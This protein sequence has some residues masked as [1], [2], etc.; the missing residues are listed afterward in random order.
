MNARHEIL[1]K[2]INKV[3]QHWKKLILMKGGSLTLLSTVAALSIG[4]LM[5]SFFELEGSARFLLM[6]G[7]VTTFVVTLFWTLVRPLLNV[8]TEIQ[9]A[10]YLEEK[11]PQLEDRLVTAVELG[12]SEHPGTSSR[13]LAQLLDD[14][15]IHIQPLNLAKSLH[16]KSAVV[17]SSF[18]MALLLFLGAMIPANLDFFTL[19]TNRIFSPWEFRNPKLF[20]TFEVSPGSKRIPKASAQEIRA[21]ITG[22]EPEE[23]VLYYSDGD[24]SWKKAE[25]DVTGDKGVFVY[26]FFNIQSETQYYVK[27]DEKL[28]DIFTFTVYEAPKINRVDLTYIYP[29]YTG[30]KSKKETDTGDVWAP[31]GT[32]IK[33]AAVADKR[34]YKAE[35]ILGENEEKLEISISADSVVTASFKVTS[36]SF[37]KILITDTDGLTND[38]PP[39]YYIHALP[40]QPPILTIDRPGHDIQA[41]MLEEVPV[42]IEVRDD[43]GLPSVKLLYTVN[44]S[45]SKELTL[46]TRKTSRENS[47]GY[48]EQTQEFTSEYLFYLEDLKVQPGDFLTYH[49]QADDSRDSKNV[50]SV[51]SEIFFIS[52]RSFD[53]EFYRSMSQGGQGGGSGGMGGKLSETQ[54][55]IIVATW[56]LQQKKKKIEAEELANN[57]HIIVESQKNLRDVTQSTL[58]QMQQRAIFSRES[59][60][61]IPK[62]YSAAIEA[63][64]RAIVELDSKQ[65]KDALVPEREA[66]QSL[67][68]AEAQLKQVQMQRAQ[69]QGAGSQATMDELA[70]LFDEEMDKLKNKYETLRQNQQQ[71]KNEQMNDALKKVKDLA[72]RQQQLNRQTRDLARKELPPQEKKRRIEELRRKQEEIRRQT[73]ELTRKMQRSGQSNSNLP[74]DV[75]DDLRRATNEMNNASNNLRQNNMDRA[76]AKGTQALNRLKRLQ[77]KLQQNQ[78]ESLRR[79]IESL[80]QQFERLAEA[81]RDLTKDV[82][83]LK[84]Q[85][86]PNQNQLQEAREKQATLKDNFETSKGQVNSLSRQ[87]R[88]NKKEFSREIN[89]LLQEMKQAGLDKK[90]ESAENL[91]KQNRLNSALQAEKDILNSLEQLREKLTNM[92]GIFAE[93]DEEKLDLALNQTRRLRENLESM[94]RETQGFER[95]KKTQQEGKQNQSGQ[96]SENRQAGPG[97]GQRPEQTV[98][99]Q[100]LDWNKQLAENLR[101]LQH[102]QRAV[103]GDSSLSREFQK[104]SQNMEG[105]IRSFSGGLPERFQLI[106][107]QVLNP[108]KAFE[109]ELAHKLEILKNKEKLFLAREEK[110]PPEYEA[111]VEKYYEVLSKTKK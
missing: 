77:E 54:K 105:M 20:P 80:E 50:E 23:V 107:E 24:S 110:I 43:Y 16:S 75:Q 68:R 7:I 8:P 18:A 90:M 104:L 109:A 70:Q 36:D 86:T 22:F 35:I 39:E 64:E 63:M 5:D 58:M 3:R 92:R 81:Q 48:F 29:K 76:A 2:R 108:L 38:P 97:E 51:T 103:Q 88:E 4:F 6:T 30:L 84:N 72:R 69:G 74:R 82:E 61:E 99:P 33:M 45:D 31:E 55:E 60:G 44:G 94:K 100:R 71:Q 32:T 47:S 13:L 62:F 40:N 21:D 34:L 91:L 67:L 66:Y 41:S 79:Q 56:K 111:L 52:I 95:A 59:D 11:N 25:M 53:K 101:N 19:K 93:T 26:S 17:W 98:D 49:V 12:G 87:A 27:A 57:I 73:Q 102:I 83:D 96:S 78:K 9:L 28:S 89:K 15:R 85:E 14:A 65:L 1:K 10:R 106:E 46:R 42:K 37:Y